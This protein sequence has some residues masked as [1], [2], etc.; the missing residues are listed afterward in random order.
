MSSCR[1]KM[2]S[3]NMFLDFRIRFFI[4]KLVFENRRLSIFQLKRGARFKSLGKITVKNP[5]ASEKTFS[6]FWTLRAA[7]SEISGERARASARSLALSSLARSRYAFLEHWFRRNTL[8]RMQSVQ[9]SNYSAYF[10]NYFLTSCH[11][12]R[13]FWIPCKFWTC[14]FMP[15]QSERYLNWLWCIWKWR[16]ICLFL[17]VSSKIK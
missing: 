11:R 7:L 3:E 17:T 14:W 12:N 1:Q 8:E 9:R 5:R 10:Y 13:S 16:S 15:W 6:K 4:L 2:T